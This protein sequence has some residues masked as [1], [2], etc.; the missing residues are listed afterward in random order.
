M[1]SVL[2]AVTKEQAFLGLCVQLLVLGLLLCAFVHWGLRTPPVRTI[3][4]AKMTM[5]PALAAASPRVALPSPERPQH[6]Q[7]ANPCP[8]CGGEVVVTGHP[9]EAVAS[10]TACSWSLT[11]RRDVA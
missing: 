2:L 8:D 9:G 5:R 7:A 3:P 11:Q 6:R 10:C 4:E 1:T